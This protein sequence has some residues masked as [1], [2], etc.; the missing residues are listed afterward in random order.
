VLVCGAGRGAAGRPRLYHTWMYCH[1]ASLDYSRAALVGLLGA[2]LRVV[3]PEWVDA[4][5]R[6][7]SC[8]GFSG[9][10]VTVTAAVLSVARMV[11]R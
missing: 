10:A 2:S 7:R 3:P 11:V 5:A 6:A 9:V 8:R 1:D 4:R